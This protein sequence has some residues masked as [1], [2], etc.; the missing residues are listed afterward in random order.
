[1][2]LLLD[3]QGLL[4]DLE[5][6]QMPTGL[7]QESATLVDQAYKGAKSAVN[8]LA[9]ALEKAFSDQKLTNQLLA[10]AMARINSSEVYEPLSDEEKQLVADRVIESAGMEVLSEA[11]FS[12][13]VK[14][15]LLTLTDEELC[16]EAYS[17]QDIISLGSAVTDGEHPE[18]VYYETGLTIVLDYVKTPTGR[19]EAI[20][21]AMQRVAGS[22]ALR[23]KYLKMYYAI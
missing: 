23:K 11:Q 14:S 19:E 6:L 18:A 4:S 7:S 12:E 1:M 9:M 16:N 5:K 8:G 10:D 3:V 17:K 13:Y 20:R 2:T 22:D 21:K 15:M